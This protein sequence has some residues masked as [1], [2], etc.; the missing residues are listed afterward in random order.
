MASVTV[1]WNVFDYKF[2]GKQRET[3]ESLAYTLFCFEFKQKFGIFRYFNQPY[4]ETQPIK[5]DDGDVIGFQ[6]KYYDET[7]QL[8]D[9]VT[10]LKKAIIGNLKS[11]ILELRTLNFNT[12]NDFDTDF[13]TDFE[14]L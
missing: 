2:S 6:A 13:D 9:K 3:F 12:D 14:P 1:D 10:D 7:T 5:T 8:A 11:F 4:I